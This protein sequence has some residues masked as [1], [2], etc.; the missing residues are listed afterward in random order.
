MEERQSEVGELLIGRTHVT[1]K[2]KTMNYF[3]WTFKLL[4]IGQFMH[5]QLDEETIGP[6]MGEKS[7]PG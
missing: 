2:R 5:F 7:S 3:H 4:L 1:N 6:G